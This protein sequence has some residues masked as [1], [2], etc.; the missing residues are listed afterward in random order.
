[1]LDIK[2]QKETVDRDLHLLKSA[3]SELEWEIK[4][5]DKEIEI[6]EIRRNTIAGRSLED[7]QAEYEEKKKIVHDLNE[8][9]DKLYNRP[10]RGTPE[11][12]EWDKWVE[13]QGG[14]EV[15]LKKIEDGLLAPDGVWKEKFDLGQ[16]IKKVRS[17]GEDGGYSKAVANCDK[18][19]DR[20]KQRDEEISQLEGKQKQLSDT[21]TQGAKEYW[22]EN[23]KY[24][25]ALYSVFEGYPNSDK[26][27]AYVETE[28]DEKIAKSKM[29]H[30]QEDLDYTNRRIGLRK[31]SQEYNQRQLEE[32]A[33]DYER[34]YYK[35][36]TEDDKKILTE[37]QEHLSDV[38]VKQKET[39]KAIEKCE[40]QRSELKSGM[41]A[42]DEKNWKKASKILEEYNTVHEGLYTDYAPYA[43]ELKREMVQYKN[44]KRYAKIPNEEEIISH[45]AGPD[46]TVGSC[47]SLAYAYFANKAGY[48]V[49]DFRGGKS[50]SVIS[51][52]CSG[53]AE[54]LGG[55]SEENFDGFKATNALLK[56]VE[57]GKEYWFCVGKHAAAIRKKDGKFEYLELQSSTGRGWHQLTTN[58]LKERFSCRKSRTSYGSRISQS[59]YL[60]EADKLTS[61]PEFISMMGYI[62]T[63]ED[64]QKKGKGGSVK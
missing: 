62:N 58:S 63:A 4:A 18:L 50:Q 24:R 37:L 43:D 38:E 45:L 48:E 2:N 40:R 11:R 60:I 61:N 46:K 53:I 64:E 10:D 33:S 39:Q 55:F 19:R 47:A 32:A 13:E 3:R 20:L 16:T 21:Y 44:L 26:V 30:I 42:E 51:R 8:L 27:K 28:T 23:E 25:D 49:L 56:R 14:R 34:E 31:V 9:N 35:K 52:V 36:R 17:Y 5:A 15:I 57:E 1:M 59:A 41:S 7:L 54:K 12:E 29:Q 6:A 22:E